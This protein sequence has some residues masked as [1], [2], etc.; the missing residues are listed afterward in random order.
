MLSVIIPAY[1][2]QENIANTAEVISGILDAEEIEFEMIFAD[3]GSKD[4]SWAEICRLNAD[5]QRVRGLR[6][7]R[8]FGKEGAIF[9][10]LRA[11]EGDCAVLIDCDLQHPPELIPQMYRMWERGAEVVEA[12]KSSRGRE[13]LFYKLFAKGFYKLMRSSSGINLD[14]ASDFKLL[15]R[16]AVN[17]LNEMPERMTFFRALSGWVGFRTE[18]I[19]FDVKPRNAGKT[20]WNYKK[21]FIFGINS[22]TSFTNF[23]MHVITLIGVIFGI[24]AV[25]MGIQTLVNYFSGSAADGFTTVILLVLILGACLMIGIG[26]IGFY[27]SKIYE[28]IK[29]RPRYIISE[30]TKRMRRKE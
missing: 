3:D 20:K 10:G 26:I 7:S 22:V 24:F 18:H 1:N 28:E 25:L 2:E 6:F 14:G 4:G 17:A 27:L 9:A 11:A 21:L 30:Y 23:P 19:E 15:D 13:S 8:N 16:K 29:R 5:D 12:R